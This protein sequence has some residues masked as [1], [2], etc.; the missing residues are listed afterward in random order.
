VVVHEKGI[1]NLTRE[2]LPHPS[3]TVG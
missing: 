1:R 3:G 2:S